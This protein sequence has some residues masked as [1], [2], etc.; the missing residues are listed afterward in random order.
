MDT[1]IQKPFITI[2]GVQISIEDLPEEGQ[3]IF[4]RIQRENTKKVTQTLDLEATQAA[5]NWFTDRIVTIINKE[6]EKGS[7]AEKDKAES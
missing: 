4:G 2:D 1:E 3:A 5:I 7:T 6:G